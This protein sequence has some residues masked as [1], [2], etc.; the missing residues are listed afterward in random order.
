VKATL[1]ERSSCCFQAGSLYRISMKSNVVDLFLQGKPVDACQREAKEEAD[2]PFENEES[3][4]VRAL[5]LLPRTP[6]CRWICDTPMGRQRLSRPNRAHFLG[7]VI[8]NAEDKIELGRA[9]L[10]KFI[11]TLAAK[12][13]PGHTGNFKLPERFRPDCA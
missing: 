1:R 8:A 12:T 7:R 3:I 6:S 5:Y 13:V 9:R 10:S 2:S 11:P 4:T